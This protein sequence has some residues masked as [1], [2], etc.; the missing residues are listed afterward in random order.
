[1]RYVALFSILFLMTFSLYANKRESSQPEQAV[2]QSDGHIPFLPPVSCEE[3]NLVENSSSN[4]CF[5]FEHLI[6]EKLQ[7]Y[8]TSKL[9]ISD[10]QRKAYYQSDQSQF[11]TIEY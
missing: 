6:P 1:M 8:E 11:S 2:C 7:C 9:K 10:P 4:W 5:K 3:H